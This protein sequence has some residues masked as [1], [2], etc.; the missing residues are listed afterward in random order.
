MPSE[1]AIGACQWMR[2]LFVSTA[3]LAGRQPMPACRGLAKRLTGKA[4]FGQ[5]LVP[6]GYGARP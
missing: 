6:P 2:R 4:Y 5:D 3:A 1:V